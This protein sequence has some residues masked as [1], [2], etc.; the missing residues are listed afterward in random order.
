VPKAA[1]ASNQKHSCNSLCNKHGNTESTSV[2]QPALPN[3]RYSS[4]HPSLHLQNLVEQNVAELLL[5][6]IKALTACLS[7]KTLQCVP[8]LMH[9]LTEPA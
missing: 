7:S 2:T 5:Q 3:N 9:L 4:C 1:V 8:S 6:H